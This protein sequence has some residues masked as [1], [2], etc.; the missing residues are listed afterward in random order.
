MGK[1]KDLAVVMGISE[2]E[3]EGLHRSVEGTEQCSSCEHYTSLG[4]GHLC[5]AAPG[6]GQRIAEIVGWVP[7][8][9]AYFLE[10]RSPFQV[11]E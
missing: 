11:V 7:G 9:C 10:A 1:K 6:G 2:G 4:E 5:M 8:K 3:K